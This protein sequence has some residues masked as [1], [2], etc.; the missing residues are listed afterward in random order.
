MKVSKTRPIKLMI[1]LTA[2][3]FF[4]ACGDDPVSSN[5]SNGSASISQPSAPGNVNASVILGK[6][7]VLHKTSVISLTKLVLSAVSSATPQD[8][9]TDTVSVTGNDAVTVTRSLTL[10]PLRNWVISAKTLDLKDSVIHS[11]STVSFYVRPADT[12]A[13]S[14]N[15]S[16]RFAMYQANFN[17]LPDSISSS[18]PGTG[19]DKLNLNRVV[20]RIDGVIKADSLLASGYFTAGQNVNVYFDYITP[21]SHTVSLEAYGDLHTYSGL[22]YSGSSTFTVAAGND[23]T[24]SLSLGW[25][26][27]TT[28][29]GALTVTL[30][31]VGTVIV[32]GVVSGDIL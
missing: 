27:P 5:S 20:L 1:A 19:K 11:G 16:S 6:V 13:V 8:T 12:T 21:G 14:L 31:K 2:P 28:G 25:V 23:D 30:G 29:T 4:A 18:T 17:A 32:N 24:R 10:K 3:F 15:L 9:V 7:G 22:L 26:G